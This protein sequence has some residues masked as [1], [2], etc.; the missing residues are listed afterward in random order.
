MVIRMSG[1]YEKSL[2]EFLYQYNNQKEYTVAWVPENYSE[3]VSYDK[4]SFILCL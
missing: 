1:E 2:I 3:I 4:S